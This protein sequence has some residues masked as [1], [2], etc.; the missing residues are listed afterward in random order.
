MNIRSALIRG[1]ET[2]SGTSQTARLD[3]ELILSSILGCNRLNLI[4]NSEDLVPPE[5]ESRFLDLIERRAR[6]E[7]V[8]YL[9]GQQ[10]FWSLPFHVAPGVLIPRPE[11]E[12]LV[13]LSLRHLAEVKPS[14]RIFVL[15]LGTGSGCIAA[16]IAREL[17]RHGREF[18]VMAVDNSD[19]ALQ[20]A[21]RNFQD[22]ELPLIDEAGM[23]RSSQEIVLLKSDWCA[24]FLAPQAR[25]DLR[26]DIV[27]SNPPYV[28]P[29]AR[30]ISPEILFEPREALFARDKGIGDIV[31]IAEEARPLIETGGAVL[32]EIGSGQGPT[33]EA[34]PLIRTLYR[35]V[36]IE[37]DLAGLDRVLRLVP[38]ERSPPPK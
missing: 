30:D 17:Q 35:D 32:L 33:L 25:K 26:F 5:A 14:G 12:L 27:V 24:A 10:E 13:E 31:R 8:A 7:P 3:A 20:I 4:T 28:D 29:E 1:T 23:G 36:T 15:D 37:R 22:L 18:L 19:G 34:H 21:R 11:T 38:G 16:A 2:L 9:I 6:H